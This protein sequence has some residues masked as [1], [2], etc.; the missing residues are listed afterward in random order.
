MTF[1]LINIML[2]LFLVHW[3]RDKKNDFSPNKF[4]R[5][6]SFWCLNQKQ[7]LKIELCK[8]SDIETFCSFSYYVISINTKN[9][10]IGKNF[11]HRYLS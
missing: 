7:K 10:F 1:H 11:Q 2:F 6:L 9:L 8:Q 5:N 3:A 4:L